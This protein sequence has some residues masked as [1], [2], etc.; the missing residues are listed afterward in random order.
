MCFFAYAA[1]AKLEIC[2][3]SET[4]ALRRDLGYDMSVDLLVRNAGNS[5]ITSIYVIYPRYVPESVEEGGPEPLVRDTTLSLLEEN[6]PANRF[7]SA[8]TSIRQGAFAGG[9]WKLT[10][11]FTEPNPDGSVIP[12]TTVYEGF[13][14]GGSRIR[15]VDLKNQQEKDLLSPTGIN[16]SLLQCVLDNPILSGESRWLRLSISASHVTENPRTPFGFFLDLVLDRLV[17]EYVIRGPINV[18]DD[19]LQKLA[20]LIRSSSQQ[21]VVKHAAAGLHERLEADLNSSSTTVNDWRLHI[22]PGFFRKLSR[23]ECEGNIR[24]PGSAIGIEFP[25]GS[26]D[27]YRCY[28]ARSGIS[29]SL[30]GEVP[31]RFKF[32]FETKHRAPL[33]HSSILA[34]GVIG[35]LGGLLC[36]VKEFLL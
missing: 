9:D 6:D 34:L 28:Q 36:L 10:L 3:A 18:R 11:T 29:G 14:R 17:H 5:S 1:K 35:S 12:L 8:P 25:P 31:G 27:I 2:F 30:I 22:F 23:V 20:S 32:A 7:L 13:V 24:Q 4:I 33:L 15:P 21:S 16:S 19:L 26:G